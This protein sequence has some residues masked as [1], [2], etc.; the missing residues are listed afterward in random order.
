MAVASSGLNK[1]LQRPW[2][3]LTSRLGQL[4]N[5]PEGKS[6]LILNLQWKSLS[7][8]LGRISYGATTC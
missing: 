2:S 4:W 3:R 1:S 5:G 7:D 6:L 8:G